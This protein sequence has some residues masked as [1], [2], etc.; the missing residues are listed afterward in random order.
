M[1]S[2]NKLATILN[3]RNIILVLGLIGSIVLF[4]IVF[5]DDSQEKEMAKPQAMPVEVTLIK[6]QNIRLWKNFSGRLT[7]VDYVEIRPQVTGLI[8]EVKFVDGQQVTKGDVLYI[9][10]PRPFIAAV[11]KAKAD[12]VAARKRYTLADKEYKRSKNLINT[13]VISQRIYDER[14]NTRLVTEAEVKSAEAQLTEAEV[15]LDH[16]YIKAPV[17]GR[18][19]R[20]E[21]T[22]GNLVASGSESP[23]L[24]TIVSSK[25]IYADFEMDEQ[26]Y[27]NYIRELSPG[28]N[29][30]DVIPVK[31]HLQNDKTMYPG[32]M[33]A[34][35]NKIDPASGTIR[36]RAIFEN[37][38][39]RLLPGMYAHIKVGSASEKQRILVNEL[40]IGTDQ[41][42][43]FVYI[44]NNENKTTYREVQLGDSV[45]GHR[46][47]RSGLNT[48]DKV[49][50]R[51]LMRIRPN[52]LVEPKISTT[53]KTANNT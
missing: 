47:I 52:M 41:N 45:D 50:T 9:I 1:A 28:Q 34:F 48:G 18:L 21:I 38:Q 19:S 16:A 22:V 10:D 24:T 2:A 15:N 14:A 17:S 25:N 37:P 53:E 5:A 40:A 23:L 29:A 30:A 20:S 8:T 36:A 39:G 35:D 3:I 51:G 26:T 44:V 49:I 11:E 33:H 27:L 43:K 6:S 42:R 31:L 7:A 32:K 4:K 12:L 13:K 46:V